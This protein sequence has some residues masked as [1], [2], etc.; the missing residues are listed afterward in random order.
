MSGPTEPSTDEQTRSSGCGQDPVRKGDAVH[1]V[2]RWCE[3][4]TRISPGAQLAHHGE[5]AASGLT[6][7]HGQSGR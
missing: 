6:P 5:A 7:L 1:R 4:A 3:V 2:S